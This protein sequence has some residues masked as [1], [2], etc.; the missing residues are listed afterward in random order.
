MDLSNVG[1]DFLALTE[2]LKLS[3]PEEVRFDIL[4][5]PSAA[6]DSDYSQRATC[7]E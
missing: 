5:A 3:D 6:D 1:G 4:S 2:L 7:A